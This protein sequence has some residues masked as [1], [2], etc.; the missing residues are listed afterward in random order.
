MVRVLERSICKLGDV[1]RRDDEYLHNV[2]SSGFHRVLDLRL[3][4]T[5]DLLLTLNRQL[6]AC[7]F[8]QSLPTKTLHTPI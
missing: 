8:H 5:Y 2:K 7:V 4:S 6:T 1:L 3:K